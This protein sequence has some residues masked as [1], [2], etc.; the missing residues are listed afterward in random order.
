MLVEVRIMEGKLDHIHRLLDS[1]REEIKRKVYMQISH[2][3]YKD[4]AWGGAG[5]IVTKEPPPSEGVSSHFQ[6]S[7]IYVVTPYA[8]EAGWLFHKLWEAFKPILD[9]MSKFTFFERLAQAILQYQKSLEGK[10]EQTDDLLDAVLDESYAILDDIRHGKLK[11]SA[12][13]FHS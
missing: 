7:V 5:V 2:E 4:Y 1:L 10:R 9:H 13:V 3:R 8:N 12:I 11:V 6:S